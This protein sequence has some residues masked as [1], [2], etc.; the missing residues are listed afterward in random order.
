MAPSQLPTFNQF[1]THSPDLER[2]RLQRPGLSTLK[3][4]GTSRSVLT[5]AQSHSSQYTEMVIESV[6][7]VSFRGTILSCF[8][9]W[10]ILAGFLLPTTFSDLQKIAVTSSTFD[11]ALHAMRNIPLYVPSLSIPL[12]L[13]TFELTCG[14]NL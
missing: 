8:L 13:F 10:V 7:S 4:G 3:G 1:P 9:H 2:R 12:V 6:E 14:I 11:K 5:L